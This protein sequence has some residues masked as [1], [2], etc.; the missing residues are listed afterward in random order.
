[1]PKKIAKPLFSAKWLPAP[2]KHKSAAMISNIAANPKPIQTA[3]FG[4]N[5]TR[6]IH[7]NASP[8]ATPNPISAMLTPFSALNLLP[9]P[10]LVSSNPFS[11]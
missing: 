5:C 1:M 9:T 8:N 11:V 2:R 3:T 10:A 7:S 4:K 6:I